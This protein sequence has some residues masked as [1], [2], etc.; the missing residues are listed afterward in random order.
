MA[1][2]GLHEF[3]E[4]LLD[5]ALFPRPLSPHSSPL[6]LNQVSGNPWGKG[7][8]RPGQLQSSWSGSV[9]FTDGVIC[10]MNKQ[11]ACKRIPDPCPP[12]CNFGPRPKLG[13]VGFQALASQSWT[14][15]DSFPV[16]ADNS[17]CQSREGTVQ[18]RP[19]K[20]SG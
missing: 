11:A 16:W 18:E 20:K 3:S 17:T 8:G 7:E 12:R 6:H 15:A 4:L 13:S 1:R 19:A 2:R 9:E 10:M 5:K 14:Q